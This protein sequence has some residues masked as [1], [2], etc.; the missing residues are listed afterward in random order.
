MIILRVF[1]GSSYQDLMKLF[2]ELGKD[3]LDTQDKAVFSYG[4]WEF[5]MIPRPNIT[6]Q[7][8][9]DLESKIFD[10]CK[11]NNSDGFWVGKSKNYRTYQ[12]FLDQ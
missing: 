2:D 8:I 1:T 10:W 5:S 6:I 4:N 12:D 7:E 9:I 11:I 3:K